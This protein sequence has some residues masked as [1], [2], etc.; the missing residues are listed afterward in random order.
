M[1]RIAYTVTATLP[2]AEVASEYIRWLQDGHTDAV[3]AGGAESA[4]IILLDPEPAEG[5]A[6][7]GVQVEVRYVFPSRDALNHYLHQYAPA[8]RADG[9]KRFGTRPG[10]VFS[11]RIGAFVTKPPSAAEA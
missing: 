6:P 5:G 11:R 1:T 4:A 10:V 9:L 7:G 3:I 8:L 2:D